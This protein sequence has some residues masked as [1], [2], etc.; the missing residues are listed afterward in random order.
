MAIEREIKL[1]MP[2]DDAGLP[3]ALVDYFNACADARAGAQ[4]HLINRYFD[5]PDL[6]LSQNAAALRLRYVSRGAAGQWLQTLKSSGTSAGGLHVRH[7]WEL[8]LTRG[9][10]DIAALLGVCDALEIA[11]TLRSIAAELRP[12]FETNFSRRIWTLSHAGTPI[13]IA[14]DQGEIAVEHD[15]VRHRDPLCELELEL[16]SQD[17]AG[18]AALQAVAANLCRRFPGLHPDD[19]SKA[20]RGYRLRQRVLNSTTDH[21][22]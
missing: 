7:E 17:A 12:L 15:G 22:G 13:E 14:L 11:A 9:E 4:Q 6:R 2:A 20:E 1:A 8:P 3:P 10:L 16:V 5:T 21:R 18:E 19:I